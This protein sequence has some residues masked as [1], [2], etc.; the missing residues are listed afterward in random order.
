VNLAAFH[1]DISDYQIRTTVGTVTSLLNAAKV[2]IDG[3]DI[4]A[5]AALTRQFH[6][7]AGAS[8]INARFGAFG[9]PSC[10]I[11]APGTYPLARTCFD[12][13]G[14]AIGGDATGNQTALA[15]HFSLNLG[16]TYTVP[17]GDERELRLSAAMTHKSSYV[18]EADN[19]LRQPAYTVVNASVEFKLDEHF[20]IEGWIRNIG[21]INY[22]VQETT[23]V[24]QTALAAP[25]RMYG[26]DIKFNY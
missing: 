25:P 11:I 8:W 9:S 14:K 3:V 20:S 23:S 21:N 7:T 10:V 6:L 24:G 22:N 13:T 12:A 1:Y 26:M 4:N 18:F 17:L 19:V 2:K 15:P 16:G 5:E